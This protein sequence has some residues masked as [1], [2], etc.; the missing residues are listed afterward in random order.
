MSAL[1]A[2]VSLRDFNT[3]R[4]QS[5]AAWFVSAITVD[6]VKRCVR[7]ARANSLSLIALGGGSNVILGPEIDALVVHMNILGRE[8]V[9][10][11]EDQV[12]VRVGA[13]EAWH[14]TVLWAH[15][16]GYYG[17]DNLALLPGSVGAAP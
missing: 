11:A 16:S 14:E 10:I 5:E 12:V 3:L 1:Q 15:Q 4:L 7:E 9:E 17:L 6:D 8:L 13:G 2:N